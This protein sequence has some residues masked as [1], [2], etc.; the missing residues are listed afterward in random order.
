MSVNW[1]GRMTYSLGEHGVVFNGRSPFVVDDDDFAQRLVRTGVFAIVAE[2]Q[3]RYIGAVKLI[4]KD[5]SE[6]SV[7]ADG[8]VQCAKAELHEATKESVI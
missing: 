1:V 4:K 2:K 6:V 5:G 8:K 3:L 7:D